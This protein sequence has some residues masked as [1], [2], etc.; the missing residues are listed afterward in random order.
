[1]APKRTAVVI[2]LDFGTTYSGIAWA[3]IATPES[4]FVIDEWPRG[5][6][7][8]T[9]RINSEK[10]PTELAYLSDNVEHGPAWGF[11]IPNTMP[12]FQWIKLALDPKQNSKL[13][14]SIVFSYKD[15]RRI[16]LSG[17]GTAEGVATDY[18]RQLTNHTRQ[19]IK[20]H[21]GAVFDSMTFQYVITVPAVWSD[22]AKNLTRMCAEK[23]GMGCASEIQMI[24][25]PE[26]AA[27]FALNSQSPH[28]TDLNVG[29]TIL[30]CDAGGG[31]VDLITFTI[32]QLRPTLRLKEAAPG[33]GALCGSSFL[34]RR[35]E[36]LVLR[37]LSHCE[38]WERD[39]LNEAM[40]RFDAIAKMF[41]GDAND[42]MSVP[43]PGI[44][45]DS[46]LNVRRGFLHLSGEEMREIFLPLLQEIRDLVKQQIWISQNKVKSVLLVGGFGQNRFLEK[47]LRDSLP[48]EI[49]LIAPVKGWTAVVRGALMK[50]LA[51]TCSLA[52]QVAI[53]SRRAR[54]HYGQIM[55]VSF[56]ESIHDTRK[57]YWDYFYGEYRIDVMS[58]FINKELLFGTKHRQ[59]DALE[60]KKPII[61]KWR[62]LKL[63]TDG[64]F[65]SIRT[66]IFELDTSEGA[67]APLYFNNSE[68]PLLNMKEH[69]VLHPE[70]N[71]ILRKRIPIVKGAD[72]HS[73]YSVNY[74]IH[75][76]YYSAHCEYSLW[77]E[78][79]KQG[80]VRVEYV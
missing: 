74:G 12:R 35:F 47:F 42:G 4:H 55:Q 69:A 54:K 33:E 45:N 5:V 56:E 80:S 9:G 61:T 6:S 20:R 58:W 14:D 53:E 19:E 10:V 46:S 64:K 59:G 73:Y 40:I 65:E 71:R 22:K 25:E 60:E 1:M 21:V 51:D 13:E 32:T 30:I 29:D 31:T 36:R 77:F 34:H 28:I 11:E 8:P 23:A 57:R 3:R 24:S 18:L 49:A 62:R 37:R 66:Q 50:A 76:H 41:G 75:A 39:T 2:A 67:D 26:A 38:G 43:V 78:G 16:A 15:S 79:Q 63:T 48:L 70:L 7:D 72:S 17:L 68:E 44:A 27:I 52:P